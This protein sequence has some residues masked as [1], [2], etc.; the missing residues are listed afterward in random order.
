MKRY[1]KKKLLPCWIALMLNTFIPEFVAAEI[2]LFTK[3]TNETATTETTGKLTGITSEVQSDSF[4]QLYNL[5][6]A[7]RLYPNLLFKTGGVFK[8]EKFTTES[9][10]IKTDSDK[11][12]LRPFI[13]CNLSTPIY[14][15]GLGYQKT[16]IKQTGPALIATR[17][18]RDEYYGRFLWEPVDLPRINLNY[19]QTQRS[20][21]PETVDKVDEL[22]GLGLRYHWKDFFINY[23]FSRND[24]EDK[25]NDVLFTNDVQEGIISHSHYFKE[26]NIQINSSYR[27]SYATIVQSAAN[28][29]LAQIPQSEALGLYLL[30]DVN[31]TSNSILTDLNSGFLVD[32]VKS[33]SSIIQLG[34]NGDET[35]NIST[36]L[37]FG[38]PVPISAL[39][40]WVDKDAAEVANAFS[41]TVYTSDD[42]NN[43]APQP[44]NKS[45]SFD[46]FENYFEISF[47]EVATRYVKVVTNP[48]ANAS[49]P[50]GN[51]LDL[52]LT[53]LESLVTKI[54]DLE[55][56]S[57]EH[58]VNFGLQWQMSDKTGFGYTL[59][60]RS[61]ESDPPFRRNRNFTNSL[62][63]HHKIS[64]TFRG[65]ANV[66]RQDNSTLGM[67]NVNH[68][69]S[70]SLIA[71]WL[72]TLRQTLTYS[73][74][75]TESEEDDPLNPTTESSKTN[76][77]V[78]RTSADLY[79]G[80]SA[81]MDMGYRWDSPT[82][83]GTLTSE[84]YRIETNIRPNTKVTINANHNYTRT[85]EANNDKT[86]SNRGNFQVSFIP[87]GALSLFARV[88]YVDQEGSS[89]NFQDY[90]ANWSPFAG[91]SLQFSFSYRENLNSEGDET[92]TISNG[93]SWKVNRNASLSMIYNII[94]TDTDL[95]FS[96]THYYLA[97]LR[98]SL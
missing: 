13:E 88:S 86:E 83:G 15:T 10:N 51:F 95:S 30:D 32:G 58:N 6:V 55:R 26:Q 90:S 8:F 5:A 4:E 39:R 52:F 38:I 97:K 81:N 73:G 40:V 78:L 20:N 62:Y 94:N 16:D 82:D 87:T 31:L 24:S 45:V 72:D 89:N 71:G 49:D 29:F 21:E 91:G 68:N 2:N 70:A 79:R 33:G 56:T 46:T 57:L 60:H 27:I 41:W 54:G 22:L 50:G 48:L 75:D 23:S 59:F 28:A 37:D 17:D 93:L 35:K 12:T 34:V 76:S 69:Y 63:W 98:V 92:E 74:T 85:Q 25:K 43:W 47:D 14:S 11:D 77:L 42:N 53:E 61:Q 3:L 7:K 36:G 19:T 18:I 96:E 84:F 66:S 64:R 44:L 65:S 67:E 1:T 80:W 9:A